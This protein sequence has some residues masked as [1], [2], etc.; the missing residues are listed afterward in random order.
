MSNQIDASLA[1]TAEVQEQNDAV[2]RL[3]KYLARCGVESRRNCEKIILEGRVTVN[4]QP[5]N[6]L[7][8]KV[9]AGKDHVEVDGVPV[10]WPQSI[11]TIMLNK[12]AGYVTTME[13]EQGRDC[14]ASLV[15]IDSIPGLYHVGRLDRDTTGLLLFSND[16]E[17]GHL[18]LHPRHH[19]KK[20]YLAYVSGVPTAEAVEALR[21]GVELDDGM[22]LP[23]EVEVLEGQQREAALEEFGFG[24][25]GA[26]GKDLSGKAR[27]GMKGS[28]SA[29][30]SVVR[31][32]IS[33]GR[34]RQ[35]RRMLGAVHCPVIA[36]HRKSMGPLNLGSLA[37]GSW[38]VLEDAE[39]EALR[40]AAQ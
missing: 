36:L 26:S 19:V 27:H 29:G 2:M 18:L 23:A 37:R 14:V 35:V 30:C 4:G 34:K 40:K 28:R 32:T 17:L 21:N 6:E 11:V 8:T 9:E 12:P 24:E 5:V 7:G 3:H 1:E 16:G 15:P 31:I 38:R 10:L 13:D 25:Q 39:V 33:E 20:T 22:T